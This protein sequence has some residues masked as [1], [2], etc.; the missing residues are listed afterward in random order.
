MG[1]VSQV[2]RLTIGSLIV[3]T[4]VAG[5]C[6][7]LELPQVSDASGEPTSVTSERPLATDGASEHPVAQASYDFTHTFRLYA[8]RHRNPARF[9]SIF[10]GTWIATRG[11]VCAFDGKQVLLSGAGQ[12]HYGRTTRYTNS[13]DS[14]VRLND[15]SEEDRFILNV[16]EEKDFQCLADGYSNGE[17]VFRECRLYAPV[18]PVGRIYGNGN[19]SQDGPHWSN[20]QW[21]EVAS[22]HYV[23]FTCCKVLTNANF[24]G[25]SHL[26]TGDVVEITVNGEHHAVLTNDGAW[27]TIVD[28]SWVGGS[29]EG[30][31]YDVQAPEHVHWTITFERVPE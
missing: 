3:F 6:E 10:P 22:P 31:T 11:E 18:G 24:W 27:T 13:C 20:V 28:V 17:L 7:D 4:I 9:D 29:P 25:E 2:R 12:A 1:T 30:L 5:G 26:K 14:V 16:G 23:T 19:G 21:S 15:L 8:E